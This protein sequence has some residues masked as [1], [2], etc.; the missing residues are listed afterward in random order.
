MKTA[1]LR[2]VVLLAGLA[3]FSCTPLQNA[4]LASEERVDR[5]IAEQEYGQALAMLEKLPLE[6]PDA[7][8][9]REQKRRQIKALM[10][11]YERRALADARRKQDQG[12]LADALALL[13]QAVRRVPHSTKLREARA[14]LQRQQAARAREIDERILIADTESLLRQAPLLAE[15]IQIKSDGADGADVR[16]RMKQTDALLRSSRSKLMEC[17]TRALD[18]GRLERAEKCLTLT[19]RIEDTP[20][21]AQAIS[22]LNDQKAARVKQARV[23]KQRTEQTQR[24]K[25]SEQLLEQLHEALAA[26]E[27]VRAQQ[28]LSQLEGLG[29]ESNELIGL[30]R[31]L[32]TA[33][34]AKVEELLEQ[35]NALYRDERV[36]EA[37][38]TWEA[39]LT[40][41]P[42]NERIQ[43]SIERANTV[44]KTLQELQQKSAL[45]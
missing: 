3:Q 10:A 27:L 40:L 37:K 4:L 30:R 17:G 31:A 45:P 28:I 21:V 22:R 39:A 32:N 15:R 41:D 33:I 16:R 43:A 8:R 24:R 26:A 14:A 38:T 9:A 19:R 2:I 34:A 18:D 7:A 44:L 20:D 1:W 6:G 29:V 13:D 11:G 12:H 36:Q 5:L 23:Q 35:G 42:L 25:E